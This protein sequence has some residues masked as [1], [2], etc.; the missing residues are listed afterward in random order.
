MGIHHPSDCT[1]QGIHS[2]AVQNSSKLGPVAHWRYT[3][4]KWQCLA[5]KLQEG[6]IIIVIPRYLGYHSS[7]EEEDS[8][9]LWGFCDASVSGYAA[10]VYLVVKTS[11]GG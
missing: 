10:V 8:Y 4:N 5:T 9:T 6:N 1:F 3:L 7:M 2:G 11:M